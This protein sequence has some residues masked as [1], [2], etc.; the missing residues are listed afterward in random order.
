MPL[1]S[2]VVIGCC[3]CNHGHMIECVQQNQVM[4]DSRQGK[5]VLIMRMNCLS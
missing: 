4:L 3:S 2:D 5:R 1:T